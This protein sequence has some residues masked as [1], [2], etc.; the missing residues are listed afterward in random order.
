MPRS[1]KKAQS[2]DGEEYRTVVGR[3]LGRVLE[4]SVEGDWEELARNELDSAEKTSC[5]S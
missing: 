2:E 5:L 4:M 3:V 1:Y